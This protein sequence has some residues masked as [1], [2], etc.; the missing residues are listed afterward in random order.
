MTGGEPF[1]TIYPHGKGQ[2]WLVNRPEFLTNKLLQKADNAVLFCRMVQAML[3]RRSGP[4]AFDEYVHGLRDRPGVAQLLF[5]PP[6]LWVTLQCIFLGG[7]ILWHFMPRFGQIRPMP[8]SRRRSKEEFLDAMATLL[9]R[10]A[11]Y[12]DAYRTAREE[13]LRDLERELGLPAGATAEH[14]A[15]EVNHRHRLADSKLQALG[16]DGL[17]G[18]SGSHGFVAALNELDDIRDEFFNRRTHR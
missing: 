8:V 17:A 15:Q 1:I 2:I 11:D 16:K 7:L 5:R 10:K 13:L 18:R 3:A 6:A 12:A 14:L 4:V 9:E